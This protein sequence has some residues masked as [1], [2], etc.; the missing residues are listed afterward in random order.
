MTV[1]ELG[2]VP[3]EYT[4]YW[5][6]TSFQVVVLAQDHVGLHDVNEST[7]AYQDATLLWPLPPK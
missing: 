7:I 4:R 1:R 3:I 6:A 5:H 2:S